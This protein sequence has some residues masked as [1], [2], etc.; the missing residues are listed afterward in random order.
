[1]PVSGM[2]RAASR[3]EAGWLR[4]TSREDTVSLGHRS[5]NLTKGT[6]KKTFEACKIIIAGCICDGSVD[7]V[8]NLYKNGRYL[9][10]RRRKVWTC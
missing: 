1:M 4:A 10:W 8:L 7:M 9:M 5:M 3:E 2:R 6:E